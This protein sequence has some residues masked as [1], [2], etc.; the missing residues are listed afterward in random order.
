QALGPGLGPGSVHTLW[1]VQRRPLPGLQPRWPP[2]RVRR[3]R[4]DGPDLGRDTSA[5]RDASQR[6]P[7]GPPGKTMRPLPRP[8]LVSQSLWKT[9]GPRE[10]IR[11]DQAAQDTDRTGTGR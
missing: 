10:V 2:A 3:L 11:P 4:L 5:V 6:S 9:T 1:R 7:G 8:G